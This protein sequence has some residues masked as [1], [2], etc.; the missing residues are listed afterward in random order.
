[1]YK[2]QHNTKGVEE[3]ETKMDELVKELNDEGNILSCLM[4]MDASL[5]DFVEKIKLSLYS[6]FFK[7][8]LKLISNAS[9]IEGKVCWSAHLKS[10]WLVNEL[11]TV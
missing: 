4:R 9:T 6:N 5:S 11:L 3:I 2:K 10:T 8:S 1:M 7:Q